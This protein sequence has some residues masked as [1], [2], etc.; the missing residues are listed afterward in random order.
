MAF[1]YTVLF[2]RS[3]VVEPE[4]WKRL[5]T[6]GGAYNAMDSLLLRGFRRVNGKAKTKV[7]WRRSNAR[8]AKT[9]SKIMVSEHK[10]VGRVNRVT[11]NRRWINRFGV[12]DDESTCERAAYER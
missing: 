9:A 8:R 2:L 10:R 1:K 12:F 4:R 3:R 6:D 7:K 5:K 11:R